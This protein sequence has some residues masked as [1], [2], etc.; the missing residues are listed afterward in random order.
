MNSVIEDPW[1]RYENDSIPRERAS[2]QEFLLVLS[3][4]FHVRPRA[5]PAILPH[6]A[7][8]YVQGKPEAQL[9]PSGLAS[10]SHIRT[11]ESQSLENYY[12]I[13]L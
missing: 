10:K 3:V 11:R 6:L 13:P 1:Y 7:A 2:R 4:R 9:R 12:V 8:A 5:Y